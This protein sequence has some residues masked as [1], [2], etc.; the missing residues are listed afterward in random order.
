MKKAAGKYAV[1]AVSGAAV[2][3]G[4]VAAAVDT[5]SKMA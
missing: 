4:I 5:A 2:G 3:G 1:V